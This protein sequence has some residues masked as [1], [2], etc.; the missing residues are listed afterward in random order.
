M[1]EESQSLSTFPYGEAMAKF[2]AKVCRQWIVTPPSTLH[3][4]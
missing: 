2:V 1:I 3:L 4:A